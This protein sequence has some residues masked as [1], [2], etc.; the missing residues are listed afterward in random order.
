MKKPTKITQQSPN[1]PNLEAAY[2]LVIT[3]LFHSLKKLK[4][5]DSIKLGNL[6]TFQKKQA[7]IT[8]ALNGKTYVYYRVNFKAS[9]TLKKELDK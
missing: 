8:T 4:D 7:Q 6:G 9:R 2:D 1:H 3:D 5:G